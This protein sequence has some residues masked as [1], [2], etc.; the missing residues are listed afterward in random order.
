VQGT[1]AGDDGEQMIV[2]LVPTSELLRYSIDLRSMSGGRGRFRFDFD[3]YDP[4]PGHLTE[5]ILA[6]QKAAQ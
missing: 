4:V 3:H 6:E 5:K 2:A 1:E